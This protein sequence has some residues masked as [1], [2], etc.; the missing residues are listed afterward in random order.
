[1]T[2]GTRWHV[3]WKLVKGIVDVLGLV[4]P[5]LGVDKIS[6]PSHHHASGNYRTSPE[7][8][9]A[10]YIIQHHDMLCL[11]KNR[12]RES[13]PSTHDLGTIDNI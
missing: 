6:C 7:P 8:I 13:I 10:L 3:C 4:R 12:G 5:M 2:A 9:T 1:M 11:L